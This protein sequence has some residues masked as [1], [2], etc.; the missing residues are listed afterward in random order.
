MSANS[1]RF[2]LNAFPLAFL[3]VA[4]LQKCSAHASSDWFFV[5]RPAFVNPPENQFGVRDGVR[6]CNP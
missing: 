6:S 4:A 3:N 2:A 1:V 5:Y